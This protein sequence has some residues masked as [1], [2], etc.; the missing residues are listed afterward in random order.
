MFRYL[1]LGGLLLLMLNDSVVLAGEISKKR[2]GPAAVAPVTIG[3]VR[4]E[5][6][7]WGRL[8]ELDQNGGY[9]AAI[10]ENSGQELWILKVYDVRYD[11]DMEDDK[12]DLFITRIEPK[13]SRTLLIENENGERFIVDLPTRIVKP[14]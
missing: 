7:P 10:D 4:Y 13:D 3:Q 5:A 2:A 1:M 9:I 14:E 11:G 6:V 12:Q 8:R